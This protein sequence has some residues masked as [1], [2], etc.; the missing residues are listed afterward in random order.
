MRSRS[1]RPRE[2]SADRLPAHPTRPPRGFE[3]GDHAARSA[4]TRSPAPPPAA[5][6]RL[7]DALLASSTRTRAIG[8]Q[9]VFAGARASSRFAAAVLM[10]G[11]ELDRPAGPVVSAALEAGLLVGSA[12]KAS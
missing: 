4:A 5:V 3:P 6:V 9:L 12:G 1:R 11:A 7:D 10:L 2:R 8:S